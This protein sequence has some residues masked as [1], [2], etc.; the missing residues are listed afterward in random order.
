MRRNPLLVALAFCLVIPFTPAAGSRL[1]ASNVAPGPGYFATDNVEWIK[2]IP[3]NTDSAGA[4]LLGNYLYVTDDRGLTIWDVGNPVD[5]QFKSF[6]PLPQQAYYS[7]EDVDTNGK[8]L[9][10]GT[11]GELLGTNTP[12]SYVSVVDVTNKTAPVVLSKVQNADNHTVTCLL[13]C[14]WAYGSSGVIIDLR[15]P[16]NPVLKSEKWTAGL[17]ISGAPHDVTEVAPGFVMTSSKP[18]TYLDV[19]SDPVHPTKV[20]T[21]SPGDNRFVHANLW[22]QHGTDDFL[23]VGGETGG[24]CNK[25]NAGAFMAFKT[26]RDDSDPTVPVKERAVIGFQMTDQYRVATGLPTEG[27][28]PYDQFCSHWFTTHP[29]YQDGG[30]VAVGWYEHGVRFLD[31]SRETVDANGQIVPGG[32][33]T[34]VGY[35]VP[36]GGSTSA[37]YWLNDEILYTIDYQR[38][39]DILRFNGGTGSKADYVP[40]PP[41]FHPVAPRAFTGLMFDGPK[42]RGQFLCPLPV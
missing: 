12:V 19:R 38:G 37:A 41:A 9:L 18:I 35:F 23:L 31:V 20:L 15:D 17:G 26:Q 32:D 7:E 22:P 36:V 10:V 14:T 21:A 2:N 34:E 1:P 29:T 16:S 13:D 24:N 5:P 4:R 11:F 42:R 40:A 33:I 39:I 8:I 3:L 6:T 25:T 27:D 28:S 30:L